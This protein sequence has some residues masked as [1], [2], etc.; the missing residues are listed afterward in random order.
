[1]GR[2]TSIGVHGV[3][4]Q[5]IGA[6][7]DTGMYASA[8]TPPVSSLRVEKDWRTDAD[9]QKIYAGCPLSVPFMEICIADPEISS[10]GDF[11][12]CGGAEY[13]SGC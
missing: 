7:M 13:R 2:F 4:M 11:I 3:G 9:S 5:I 6:L 1:M 12:V 8:H 10:E